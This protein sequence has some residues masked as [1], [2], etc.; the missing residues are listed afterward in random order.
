MSELSEQ[1]GADILLCLGA[2]TKSSYEAVVKACRDPNRN[3]NVHLVVLT[4]GGDPHAA[5]RIG[6]HIQRQYDKVTA[7]VPGPC[8]SAGTLLAVAAH[9]LVMSEFGLLGPLDMQVRKTDELVERTSGL[10]VAEAMD[11]LRQEAVETLRRT[12][13]GLKALSPQI[14]LKTALDAAVSLTAGLLQPVSAQIDPIRLGEDNRST[15]VVR[16]YGRR[17]NDRA[18]NLREGALDS[19]VSS[20]P[21][22]EFRIDAWEADQELFQNVR[23]PSDDERKLAGLLPQVLSL[24]RALPVIKRFGATAAAEGGS[25]A[26]QDATSVQEAEMGGDGLPPSPAM[27]VD[28]GGSA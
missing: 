17:L 22:H 18:K 19:L 21:S 13:V 12:L 11:S 25:D 24:Y 27:P 4:Y 8:F 28:Q 20:Y 1:H 7:F 26:T 2:I 16:E 6:R 9:E 10:T 15:R 14:T 5:Y 3:R 23:E